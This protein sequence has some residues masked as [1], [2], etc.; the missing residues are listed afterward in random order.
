MHDTK[1]SLYRHEPSAT[2]VES[3][4]VSTVKVVVGD[5]MFAIVVDEFVVAVLDAI[6]FVTLLE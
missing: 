3:F 4:V 1:I 6:S 5:D 2:S